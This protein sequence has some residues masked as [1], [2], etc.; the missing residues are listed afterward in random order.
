MIDGDEVDGVRVR[1]VELTGQPGDVVAMMP[2]T[3]HNFSMNTTPRPRFMVTHTIMRHDQ[4]Y[5]P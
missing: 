1:V 3:M 4:T 2:W 5:Y